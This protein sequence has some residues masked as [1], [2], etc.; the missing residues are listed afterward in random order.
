MKEVLM[1]EIKSDPS[2]DFVVDSKSDPEHDIHK[3]NCSSC[4]NEFSIFVPKKDKG[5]SVGTAGELDKTLET[6]LCPN[7]RD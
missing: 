4:G 6:K 7:C 1:P 5:C 3:G 2:T